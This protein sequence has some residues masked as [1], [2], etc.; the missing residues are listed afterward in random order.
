MATTGHEDVID[1]QPKAPCNGKRD[2]KLAALRDWNCSLQMSNNQHTE[3]NQHAVTSATT[4]QAQQS[5]GHRFRHDR[6][7]HV[8]FSAHAADCVTNAHFRRQ[9]LLRTRHDTD[10]SNR[11]RL[12][13]ERDLWNGGAYGMF[14]DFTSQA[15]LLQ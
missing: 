6:K 7:R 1:D 15:L 2:L 5:A 14:F 3:S 13:L 11:Y 10:D 9:R 4:P 12:R 8:T